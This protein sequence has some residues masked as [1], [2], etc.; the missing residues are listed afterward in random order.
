MR[1]LFAAIFVWGFWFGIIG[2]L[3]SSCRDQRWP[4][5]TRP[6][7]VLVILGSLLVA[8]YVFNRLGLRRKPL[9]EHLAELDAK[10]RLVRQRF[11]ATR[12]F[13]VEAFED[14]GLHFY[15]ELADGRVLYL[16]GQ[17]LYDYEPIT[18][19]PEF[20]QARSF[21]C[22]EF[23][24]LRH[25]DAGY[26]LHIDCAGTVLEPGIMAQP[27]GRADFRRGMPEDGEIIVDE[28]YERIKRQ[29]ATV[30]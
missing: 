11:Q 30:T 17:Y 5:W 26:V 2:M 10:G 4:W 24:V 13:A 16:N 27:F 7:Q 19:D 1:V 25:K 3:D 18:D 22:T 23:A 29:R 20:N 9:T 15:I 28:S 21:P 12:A 6:L 14:E 8:A